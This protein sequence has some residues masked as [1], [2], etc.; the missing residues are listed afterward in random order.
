M[1]ENR[2]EMTIL[3]VDDSQ[4][5]QTQFRLLLKNAGYGDVQFADDAYQAY[6]ILGIS[7]SSKV[8]DASPQVDLILMDKV[9]PEV[10][11]IEA[12]REIKKHAKLKDI[13]IIM[14][15]GDS[16]E[17]GLEEA[18]KSGAMD[19]IIK[20][21]KKVELFARMNSL[22]KLKKEIDDRKQAEEGLQDLNE[23]LEQRVKERTDELIKTGDALKKSIE[24]IKETQEKLM[25]AEKMASLGT[26]VAGATHEINTPLGISISSASSL[27]ERTNQVNKKFIN[28]DLKKSDFSN[29]LDHAQEFSSILL[30]NL[31]RSA[32]LVKSLKVVA[33]DQ[34]SE[35]KR[36]FLVREYLDEIFLSLRPKLKRTHH[37]VEINC[38][39]DLS[40]TNYPG[41]FSQIISNLVLN[42]IL[43][44]FE[45]LEEGLIKIDVTPSDND[46]SLVY[47]DNGGGISSENQKKI[48]DPYFTTKRGKG[49][50][51]LGMHI[52]HNLVEEKLKGKI[53]L[54]SELEK[55]VKFTITFPKDQ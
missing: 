40:V 9:M 5:M 43:H 36:T 23:A 50:S 12:C 20:P 35:D 26:L 28:G 14:V 25:M 45:N 29:F 16:T 4:F 33:V 32:D 52:V 6:E 51:G 8:C 53:S 31:Q 39:L 3:V 27:K 22:L 37:T 17:E 2:L 15:T 24:T 7:E 46:I 34:C 55:G 21:L 49:G 10:G 44:G 41:Y 11:G 42:S 48:F 47:S 13:P 30:S 18:F 54:E 1:Y 38:P 19:Y